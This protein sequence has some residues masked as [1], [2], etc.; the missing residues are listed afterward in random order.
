V[1][2]RSVHAA[3]LPRRR[4]PVA[5]CRLLILLLGALALAPDPAESAPV[6]VRFPEGLTH[7]FLL[8]RSAAGDIVGH[9]EVTQIV[10]EGGV[11]ESRLVL[12]FKDGS[13]HDEKVAFSQHRVF[14]LIRYQLTQRG[15][16]FPE[17]MEVMVDR[18]TSSY[19]VRSRSGEDGKEK[20]LTGDI[21]VPKDAYNGMIVTTLLNLPKGATETVNVLA[22]IPEPT[23][24]A[25]ELAFVGEQMIR[26]GDQS[27]KAWQYAF[28]P[29]I[30]PVKKFVGTILG[31]LP[32]DF[33]YDCYILA[34]DV[35]SFV[36]FEGPLQLMGPVWSIELMSP[37]MAVKAEDRKH[38]PR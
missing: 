28:K 17:Q 14:T 2:D 24:I 8:V 21:D 9:G 7:G 4:S 29:E 6:A 16:S 38:A 25:L 22:F 10:K 32:A 26:V 1:S 18:G 27:R 30:G 15:P 31:K 23:P 34:D 20:V 13:L 19:E 3:R 5:R 11:A 12:R 35:P 36:R 37:Q 33:H